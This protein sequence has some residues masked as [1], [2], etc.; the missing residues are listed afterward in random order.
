MPGL[1]PVL[2]AVAGRAD[3]DHV[4]TDAGEKWGR[5][6]SAELIR[7][8]TTPESR[9]LVLWDVVEEWLSSEAFQSTPIAAIPA[10]RELLRR[11]LE[12]LAIEAGAPDPCRLAYQ[13]QML[14]EGTV[15]GALIDRRLITGAARHLTS[16]AFGA[17]G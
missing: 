1:S 5:W 2:L 7:R 4:P 15:V 8:G 6:L 13:L 10:D 9:L 11:L 12:R 3:V 14:F 16:L 17:R